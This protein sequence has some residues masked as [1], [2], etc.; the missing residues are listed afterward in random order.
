MS[1]QAKKLDDMA[2]QLKEEAAR[3]AHYFERHFNH[4]RLKN[5]AEKK[6]EAMLLKT[7]EFREKTG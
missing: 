1:L 4:E 6:R 5:D 2:N 7:V 3:Y